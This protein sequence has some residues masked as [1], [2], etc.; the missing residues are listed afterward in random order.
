MEHTMHTRVAGLIMLA[1][2]VLGGPSP[3][4]GIAQ[5]PPTPFPQVHV[6]V[7]GDPAPIETLRLAILT[8]TRA[9]VPEARTGQISLAETAPPL[10]P[11][12]AASEMS[13]RAVVQ[14]SPV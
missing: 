1:A 8:T 9:M 2:V 13:L 14:V 5:V 4:V 10:Q 7:T 11:L 3:R 6:E 12:P